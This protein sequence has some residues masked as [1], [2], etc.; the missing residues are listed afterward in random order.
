MWGEAASLS[1][2]L[3]AHHGDE[4]GDG[5]SLCFASRSLAIL[6]G[7]GLQLLMSATGNHIREEKRKE[8]HEPFLESKSTGGEQLT[9]GQCTA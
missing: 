9:C 5:S 1:V 3:V 7:H 6:D 2:I 4:S 8:N